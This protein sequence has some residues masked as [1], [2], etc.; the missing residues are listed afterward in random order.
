VRWTREGPLQ[1]QGENRPT[2]R[3]PL[4]V[5]QS[6]KREYSEIAR[7]QNIQ[8]LEPSAFGSG[9]NTFFELLF[10]IFYLFYFLENN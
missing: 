10:Y 6:K 2:Q 7:F 3:N 8:K 9:F 5:A 4:A 1:G